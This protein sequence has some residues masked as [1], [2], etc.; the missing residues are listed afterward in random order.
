MAHEP[1]I[2]LLWFI[3]VGLLLRFALEA[4]CQRTGRP[5]GAG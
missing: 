3:P 5:A 2:H 1:F 4:A